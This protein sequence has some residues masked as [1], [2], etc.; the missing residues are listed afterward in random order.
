MME[1]EGNRGGLA[2]ARTNG[3]SDTILAEI[4]FFLLTSQSAYAGSFTYQKDFRRRSSFP[5]GRE[6][7]RNKAIE[8]IEELVLN[9]LVEFLGEEPSVKYFE[10]TGDEVKTLAKAVLQRN[11][12]EEKWDGQCY[13][14]RARIVG[15]SAN[16]DVYPATLGQIE[17]KAKALLDAR[18]RARVILEEVKKLEGELEGTKTRA[19][20]LEAI[21]S[22][23]PEAKEVAGPAIREG[24][25][26][27]T[28][29][30][31]A[32]AVSA[33]E[34]A[35]EQDSTSGAAFLGR[36]AAYF[37]A[38]E[39]D[40]AVRDFERARELSPSDVTAHINLG[41]ALAKMGSYDRALDT[42]N[43]ALTLD[44]GSFEA[45]LNRGIIHLVYG[46]DID[47]APRDLTEAIRLRP[48]DY[49]G[50]LNRAAVYA[51]MGHYEEAIDDCDESLA[52]NPEF[53]LVYFNRANAR[54]RLGDAQKAIED[55]T[56]F[57][58]RFVDHVGGYFNRALAYAQIGDYGKA[59]SDFDRV[60]TLDRR[61]TKALV[62]RGILYYKMDLMNL[63][64]DDWQK[65]SE[66]GDPVG[67]VYLGE[68]LN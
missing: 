67:K 61:Q 62:C 47:S 6:T 8:A 38:K 37:C 12:M 55:Y 50:Y 42:L 28:M 63:A 43:Q 11:V 64:R 59:L 3:D 31:Y 66:L 16:S 21:T 39:Y 13:Y 58:E 25:K 40:K 14:L 46:L 5:V 1:M 18:E 22:E 36:G 7:Y 17:G 24:D 44:P 34:T 52:R 57:V 56:H 27:W 4:T 45:W 65:A 53:A 48:D 54:M 10:L 32:R 60:I 23:G 26:L 51:K 49:R 20:V 30:D 15:D 29:G 68:I 35:I 2:S 9:E 33:Y 41:S 19:R